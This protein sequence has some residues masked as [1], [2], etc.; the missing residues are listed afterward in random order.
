MCKA[1]FTHELGR[2]SGASGPQLPFLTCS[3][4]QETVCFR[5]VCTTGNKPC[6]LGEE[7][8]WVERAGGRT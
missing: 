5:H 1:A 8:A 2:I 3:A 4:Q 7:A 6:G